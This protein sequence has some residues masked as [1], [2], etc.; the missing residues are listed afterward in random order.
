[1]SEDEAEDGVGEV[2]EGGGG[3]SS[4]RVGSVGWGYGIVASG[5]GVGPA[6]ASMIGGWERR[7]QAAA[8]WSEQGAAGAQFTCFTSTQVQK[9]TEKEVQMRLR[10][11]RWGRGSRVRRV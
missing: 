2:G 4:G 8:Y 10:G 5:G 1:V 11:N 7:V 6:L 3:G 9:M